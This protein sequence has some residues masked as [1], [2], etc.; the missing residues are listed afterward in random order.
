MVRNLHLERHV[1]FLGMQKN[2]PC[3]FKQANICVLPSLQEAFGY[4]IME[5]QIAG[6]PVV[7]TDA[8]GLTEVVIHGQTGLISQKG[9]TDS[10][11]RNIRQ[12]MENESLRNTMVQTLKNRDGEM[13]FKDN[14]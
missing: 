5:A 6:R 3:H 13:D 9:N 1:I 12:L 2:V 7:V 8:G 10:L 11:Y 4:A 14:D